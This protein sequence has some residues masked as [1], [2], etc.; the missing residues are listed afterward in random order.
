[1]YLTALSRGRIERG[2]RYVRSSFWQARKFK[3]LEDLNAQA[4]KW[5]EEEAD[6]RKWV[7]D[8]TLTVAQAFEQEKSHLMS[9]PETPYV[10]YDRKEVHVGKTPY[11]RFD[12][13]YDQSTI[14]SACRPLLIG[15]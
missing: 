9:V 2:I 6:E 5:C 1:M 11:I 10:V 7:Q 8:R 15:R 3:D 12:L 4:L 13:N 14:M